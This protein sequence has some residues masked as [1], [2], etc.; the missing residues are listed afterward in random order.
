MLLWLLVG[1]GEV[2]LASL[3]GEAF[4]SCKHDFTNIIWLQRLSGTSNIITIMSH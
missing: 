2:P 1:C 3:I 4:I